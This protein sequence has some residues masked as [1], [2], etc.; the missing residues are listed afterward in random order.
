MEISVNE[1]EMKKPPSFV[2]CPVCHKDFGSKSITLHLPKCIEKLS[3]Q[4]K[5]LKK[6]GRQLKKEESPRPN[7]VSVNS[8]RALKNLRKYGIVD[9]TKFTKDELE[10]ELNTK[11]INF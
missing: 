10:A 5:K 9:M 1:T 7:T 4:D 11:N 3:N 2:E 6:P 8:S